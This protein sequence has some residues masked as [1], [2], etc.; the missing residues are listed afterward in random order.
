[1]AAKG[2][3]KHAD[4]DKLTDTEKAAAA[5]KASTRQSDPL[6]PGNEAGN[7]GNSATI[8]PGVKSTPTPEED[9]EAKARAKQAAETAEIAAGE[10]SYRQATKVESDAIARGDSVL[11]KEVVGVQ[12]DQGVMQTARRGMPATEPNLSSAT[13]P[14]LVGNRAVIADT[15]EA[16]EAEA[17]H[18]ERVAKDEDLE[19]APDP[20]PT[21]VTDLHGKG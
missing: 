13:N 5:S 16:K 12:N 2:T 10:G 21:V 8:G 19:R 20:G 1:M 17:D 4:D 6:D 11:G 9:E 3:T 15:P 7:R 18:K 14:A